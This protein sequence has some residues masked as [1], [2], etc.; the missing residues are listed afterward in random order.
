MGVSLAAALGD[1]TAKPDNVVKMTRGAPPKFDVTREEH[2]GGPLNSNPEIWDASDTSGRQE[3]GCT[4]ISAR[5]PHT[6][7]TADE[8]VVTGFLGLMSRK[9]VGLQ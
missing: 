4:G 7:G 3:T 8:P 1:G 5:P 9:E 2:C 6:G